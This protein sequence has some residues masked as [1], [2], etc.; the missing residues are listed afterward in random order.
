MARD[1]FSAA[2]VKRLRECVAYRCMICWTQTLGPSGDG[3]RGVSAGVASHISGAAEGGP[4]YNPK[5]TPEQRSAFENGMWL[6][7]ICS[8]K[9]DADKDTYTEPVLVDLRAKAIER[10][11]CEHG[12]KALQP[13]DAE[14]AVL[15]VLRRLPPK[16]PLSAIASVHGAAAARLSALDPR[17]LVETGYRNQQP[18]ISLKPT[19]PV[20]FILHVPKEQAPIWK[21]GLEHL[22]SHGEEVA[23][24]MQGVFAQ[25][26]PLLEHLIDGHAGPD[27]Q[28]VIGGNDRPAILHVCLVDPAS[29]VLE[30]LP[31]FVGKAFAG[32][33]SFSVRSSACGGMLGLRVRGAWKEVSSL[34]SLTL[35]T[36]FSG[37]HGLDLRELPYLKT[38]AQLFA[39]L[40]I[41]WRLSLTLEVDGQELLKATTNDL[42]SDSPLRDLI[43]EVKHVALAGALAKHLGSTI[44]YRSDSQ[45]T[46][47]EIEQ[48]ETTVA[49]A[50]GRHRLERADLKTNPRCTLIAG[51]D[52]Q[53][54]AK[55]LSADDTFLVDAAE[56]EGE[57]ISVFGQLVKLPRRAALMYGVLPQCSVDLSTLK[58]GDSADIEWIP[59]ENFQLSY[60]FVRAGEEV[61]A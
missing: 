31:D 14:D 34:C 26:S 57:T 20:A 33:E 44:A 46:W 17:F 22:T 16:F 29:G 55:H 8:R 19:Q 21:N 5:L 36:N 50:N 49:I 27:G 10:A 60:R 54:M 56:P 47:L 24:P 12:A 48:V 3:G 15:A 30:P 61:A 32:T 35:S 37:W 23:L 52:G 43:I 25:G 58:A 51:I 45:L 7:A 53:E 4:R 11:R 9:I 28:L 13:G 59:T 39:R 41:G 2:V 38:I 42:D 1:D 6:C 18:V 40:S